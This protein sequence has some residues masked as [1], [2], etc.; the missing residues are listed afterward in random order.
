M[1]TKKFFAILMITIMLGSAAHAEFVD[2][3]S[4]NPAYEEISVLS[5]LGIINGYEDGSFLPEAKVTRAEFCALIARFIGAFH[6]SNAETGFTDVPYE[7]W[8]SGYISILTNAGIINGMGDGRFAPEAEITYEQ[9]VKMIV[10]SLAYEVMANKAGGYPN[11]YM[12]IGNQIGVTKGTL[13]TAGGLSRVTVARL[14]FN[15]LTT[16]CIENGG[17]AGISDASAPRR[18]Y[19]TLYK[20]FEI[21]VAEAKIVSFSGNMANL[22]YKNLDECAILNGWHINKTAGELGVLPNSVSIE[23]VNVSDSLGLTANVYIDISDY[24]NFKILIS[25]PK[26]DIPTIE[27]NSN[28][29]IDKNKN[30]Y[31]EY[32]K[33]ET[34]EIL[35]KSKISDNIAVYNNLNLAKYDNIK[36]KSDRLSPPISYKYADTDSDG[37]FDT[38]FIEK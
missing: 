20:K 23:G 6:V 8:A 29:L 31:I 24:Q 35:T 34:D 36:V 26:K 37:I 3:D 15:A 32:Y 13:Q 10:F 38:V 28:L 25:V 16:P 4:D 22:E 19:T 27:T 21:I 2:V 11:G 18:N 14:L 12:L 7:H 17:Y 9:A 30:G 33:T 1:K 5:A